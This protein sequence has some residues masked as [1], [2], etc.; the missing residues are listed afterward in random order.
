MSVTWHKKRFGDDVAVPGQRMGGFVLLAQP[1]EFLPADSQATLADWCGRCG[2]AVEMEEA[3]GLVDVTTAE[4][5]FKT[6]E[7]FGVGTDLRE[8]EAAWGPP[9]HQ[10][11]LAGEG[12]FD[13]S[14]SWRARGAGFAV[15]DGKVLLLSVFPADEDAAR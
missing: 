13:V 4:P 8:I 2:V 1:A 14:L 6:P 3:R 12:L 7:G 9:D 10:Q 15:K 11:S 5:R